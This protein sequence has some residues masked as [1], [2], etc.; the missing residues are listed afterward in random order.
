MA[1]N[2]FRQAPTSQHWVSARDSSTSFWNTPIQPCASHQVR[3]LS[4]QLLPFFHP[5]L[6]S[7]SKNYQLFVWNLMTHLL[8]ADKD[9]FLISTKPLSLRSMFVCHLYWLVWWPHCHTYCLL[10]V[11]ILMTSF[12]TAPGIVPLRNYLRLY[13][14]KFH[15]VV[16]P[17]HLLITPSLVA[18]AFPDLEASQPSSSL[19]SFT[20]KLGNGD[21]QLQLCTESPKKDMHTFHQKSAK[22]TASSAQS[23]AEWWQAVELHDCGICIIHTFVP[24]AYPC[25]KL[26]MA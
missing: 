15:D 10:L 11:N 24:L 12:N 26:W 20:S 3:V 21:C 9:C 14:K 13:Q 2:L 6:L 1:V 16:F 8:T 17:H 23:G 25:G 4:A 5:V 19:G 7:H 22:I 18:L